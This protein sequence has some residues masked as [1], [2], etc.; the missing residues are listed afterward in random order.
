M[1]STTL[2]EKYPEIFTIPILGEESIHCGV[3][4]IPYIVETVTR[5]LPSSTYVT[6]T[7]SHLEKLWLPKF[8]DAFSAKATNA[9]FLKKIIPPGEQIKSREGKAEIEDFLI[10]HHCTRDTVL[11]ALGGGVVGDLV[12][13]VAATL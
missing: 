8:A 10:E 13:F 11:L 9:R 7:D 2:D 3:H 4:L 1:A 5:E 12:G 6:I